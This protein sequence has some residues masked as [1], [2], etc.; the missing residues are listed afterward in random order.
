MIR[1][2]PFL[3]TDSPFLAELWCSQPPLRARVQPMTVGLLEQKVLSKPYFDP[4]GLIVAEQDGRLVGYAHA[5]FGA[6]AEASA[7]STETGTTCMLMVAPHTDQQEIG[8]QLLLRSEQYL[9]ER[10]AQ[11]LLGG[12]VAPANPFYLGLYGD[13]DS[14]GILES[15]AMVVQLFV[16]AGY[17]VV[18]Q[19]AVLERA[20]GSFRPVVDRL[21][22][23]LRRQYHVEVELDPPA[24]SWWEACTVGQTQRIRYRVV[25]RR[26]GE[27]CGSVTFWDMERI[28]TS[29]GLLHAV[30]MLGLEIQEAWRGRGLGTFLTG[31][32]LRRLHGDQPRPD[33]WTGIQACTAQVDGGNLAALALFRKLGFHEVDRGLLV[34]KSARV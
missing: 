14:P 9:I 13:N 20:L 15:N 22:M 10:G 30:G 16:N 12:S 11:R 33:E 19:Q 34:V 25:S 24:R 1:Y 26:S 2:R 4:H 31:E 8:E 7:I 23:Q 18:Q 5:G 21:Q 32:A 27:C 17:K 6:N 3:N 28:A 29:R